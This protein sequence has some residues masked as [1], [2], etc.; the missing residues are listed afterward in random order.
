[1]LIDIDNN[2]KGYLKSYTLGILV[3]SLNCSIVERWCLHVPVTA[4]YI[5]LNEMASGGDGSG[6]SGGECSGKSDT[7]KYF[8]YA[9]FGPVCIGSLEANCNVYTR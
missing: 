5:S 8:Q 9:W 3:S 1:M 4:L 7:W 6:R 2:D